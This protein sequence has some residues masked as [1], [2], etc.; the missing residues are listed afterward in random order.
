M[1]SKKKMTKMRDRNRE[2]RGVLDIWQLIGRVA[3]LAN[4]RRLFRLFR[5]IRN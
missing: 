4:Y 3:N 5:G 2:A 1:R